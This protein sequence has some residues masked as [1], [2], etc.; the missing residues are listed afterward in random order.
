M[1]REIRPETLEA[2]HLESLGPHLLGWEAWRVLEDFELSSWE[3]LKEAVEVRFGLSPQRVLEAF[4]AM[5]PA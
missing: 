5:R 2:P 3:E 4:K 1:G